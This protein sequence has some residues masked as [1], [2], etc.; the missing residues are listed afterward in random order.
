MPGDEC[1]S[2][3]DTLASVLLDEN[4]VG[5]EVGHQSLG[6]LE[7]IAVDPN[8]CSAGSYRF[9]TIELLGMGS[10]VGREA[11]DL[12]DELVLLHGLMDDAEEADI[13]LASA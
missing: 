1:W 4:A 8:G 13:V 6:G 12:V 11:S 7:R 10:Y 9:E 5:S 3:Y 2:C